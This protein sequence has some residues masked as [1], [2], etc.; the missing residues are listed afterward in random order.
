MADP[1]GAIVP[2]PIGIATT[3]VILAAML[4]VVIA[5]AGLAEWWTDA[6]KR[7]GR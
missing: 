4:L 7:K 2:D 1:G 6:T 3:F 5:G